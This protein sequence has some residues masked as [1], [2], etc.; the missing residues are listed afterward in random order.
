[1]QDI[2]T[3]RSSDFYDKMQ[4]L[5]VIYERIKTHVILAEYYNSKMS[6]SISVINELRNVFDHV[7]RSIKHEDRFPDEMKKAEGHLLRAGFD[8]CEI[9]IIDRLEYLHNFKNKYSFESIQK[10]YPRYSDE[11][12]SLI[13]DTKKELTHLRTNEIDNDRLSKYEEIVEKLIVV[14]DELDK[15]TR[16]LVLLQEKER[17]IEIVS[18]RNVTVFAGLIMFFVSLFSLLGLSMTV[19]ISLSIGCSSLVLLSIYLYKKKLKHGVH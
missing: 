9:I 15:N 7:M 18:I 12:L 1:M 19:N 17:L 14:C 8:A 11:V 4:E 2:S 6:I 10:V 5:L 3:H 13:S 16:N